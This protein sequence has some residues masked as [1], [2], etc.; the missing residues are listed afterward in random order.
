MRIHIQR[1]LS[2]LMKR[3]AR[4]I[5]ISSTLPNSLHA[6][7]HLYPHSSFFFFFMILYKLIMCQI[8]FLPKWFSTQ[9]VINEDSLIPWNVWTFV[10][11]SCTGLH[12]NWNGVRLQ[13][14]ENSKQ[15]CW[16]TDFSELKP[17]HMPL[18]NLIDSRYKLMKQ[19]SKYFVWCRNSM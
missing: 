6:N 8:I 10:I 7:F 13:R 9:K 17:L 19:F 5:I 1:H 2:Y 11:S 3:S 18:I 16:N 12:V 4:V 14:D 15:I